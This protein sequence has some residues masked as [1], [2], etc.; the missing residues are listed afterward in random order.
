MLAEIDEKT[1][2]LES[3]LSGCSQPVCEKARA[4]FDQAG[5]K[6]TLATETWETAKNEYA[7]AA[8]KKLKLT[9]EQLAELRARFEAAVA[10]LRD[11]IREWHAAHQQLAGQLT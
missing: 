9:K 7:K 6:L 4:L 11:A 5:E 10:E 8:Q 1:R 2:L 3:R